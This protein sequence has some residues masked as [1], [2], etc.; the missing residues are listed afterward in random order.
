M[1]KIVISETESA[2]NLASMN[3]TEL[4]Q[5]DI[6]MVTLSEL[7]DIKDL[8]IDPELPKEKRMEA[9]LYQIKNPYCFKVGE[10][11]VHVGFSDDGVT[12]EQRMEHY[13]QTL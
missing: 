5:M 12:F 10:I 1:H 8:T 3:L 6:R 2:Q 7:V 11:A 4:R 13:L 9:F